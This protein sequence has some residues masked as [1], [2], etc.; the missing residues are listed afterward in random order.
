[1]GNPADGELHAD[2][3]LR[4][5]PRQLRR[6]VAW[7]RVVHERGAEREREL[8]LQL[9]I[10]RRRQ[11]PGGLL[12]VHHAGGGCGGDKPNLVGGGGGS[13][14]VSARR[15]AYVRGAYRDGRRRRDG[16]RRAHPSRACGGNLH[17][18]GGEP[19][20][21]RDGDVQPVRKIPVRFRAGD[22]DRIAGR[23][24]GLAERLRVHGAQRGVTRVFTRSRLAARPSG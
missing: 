18:R 21:R 2:Y 12:L 1:M 4:R 8:A 14:S 16:K 20:R 3:I 13:A 10:R 11:Q 5:R 19:S 23:R 22:A 7:E 9:R 15:Y 6:R 17:D 24:R